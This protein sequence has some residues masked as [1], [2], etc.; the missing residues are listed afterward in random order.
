MACHEG[1]KMQK[2]GAFPHP[3][4]WL[5]FLAQ[6]HNGALWLTSKS[7]SSGYHKPNRTDSQNRQTAFPTQLDKEISAYQPFDSTYRFL[8]TIHDHSSNHLH[9][10]R[11]QPL[12]YRASERNQDIL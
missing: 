10:P 3:Y 2:V 4:D 5:L 9:Y 11:Q 6:Y 1:I 7:L 12:E 8:N